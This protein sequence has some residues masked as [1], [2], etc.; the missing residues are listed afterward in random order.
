MFGALGNVWLCEP[1]PSLVEVREF[2]LTRCPESILRVFRGF[3]KPW[4]HW[5]F[6]NKANR[7]KADSKNHHPM[8]LNGKC[9]ELKLSRLRV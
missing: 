6:L 5:D 3:L 8:K 2:L 1:N 9:M 4:G 7:A